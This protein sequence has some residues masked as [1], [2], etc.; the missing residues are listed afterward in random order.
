MRDAGSRRGPEH[1]PSE[2]ESSVRG[3]ARRGALDRVVDSAARATRTAKPQHHLRRPRHD[4]AQAA[5]A[6]A[7]RAS[8]TSSATWRTRRRACSS[9]S[10]SEGEGHRQR[11]QQAFEHTIGWT[12]H[13]MLGRSFLEIVQPEDDDAR[14]GSRSPAAPRAPTP[15][16]ASSR[17]R[18]REGGRAD[19]RLDGDADRRHRPARSSSLICGVDVTERERREADLR[20]SEERLRAAIEASPVAIVEYALDDTIMRWNRRGGADLRLERRGGDR[21]ECQ[22]PAARIAEAELAELFRRV[23]A[24]EVYTGVES[25]QGAQGRRRTSKSRSPPRPIR[26]STGARRSATWRCSPTS[27]ERKRHEEELRASRARI[28]AGRRTRR[29]GMLERNLHDGAQ[30]RLVALS[31]SL[32][33]AQSKLTTDPAAADAV[34]D[35]AREEL[36]AAIEELRE[37]ARGIHPA[38]LTDRGLEAAVEAL[39]TRSP[40]PVEFA[41][42]AER[43][44]ARGRGGGLLRD[45]RGA[46]RTSSSTPAQPCVSVRVA[47]ENGRA[48]VRSPTTASAAPTRP[49]ASGLSG[50]A[51]RVEAL[52]GSLR[53]RARPAAAP[54]SPP[55]S[56]CRPIKRSRAYRT[57]RGLRAASARALCDASVGSSH[58]APRRYV[59]FASSRVDLQTARAT[60]STSPSGGLPK[61]TP[62]RSRCFI[63]R[64]SRASSSPSIATA[65]WT[66]STTRSRTRPAGAPSY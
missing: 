33:L 11:R 9:S 27:R 57:S 30:Q 61:T 8:A 59:M 46:R 6:R 49:R 55:R 38:V 34:L 50:L 1:P 28:V 62:S 44:A 32:R 25:T 43:A 45:R 54:A 58:E 23:R 5:R 17:W 21:R 56:R 31:L 19:R 39:A 64:A 16:S 12:E 29:G 37:L 18:T 24:G 22:A 36:A 41:T 52:G 65:P 42:P 51:D 63:S 7:R 60:A 14:A 35:S 10:T 66:P 47:R 13:E 26:D 48:V 3:P 53:S 40:V 20:S 15:K 4:R 2:F